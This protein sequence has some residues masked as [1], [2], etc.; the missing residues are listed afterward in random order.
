[1]NYLSLPQHLQLYFAVSGLLTG[2]CFLSL[3]PLVLLDRL[4]FMKQYA[5]IWLK[6]GAWVPAVVFTCLILIMVDNYTYTVFKFGIVSSERWTRVLYAAGF[7]IATV[8]TI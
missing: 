4:H 8:C 2:L 1:M 6:L 7:V 5:N 3:L